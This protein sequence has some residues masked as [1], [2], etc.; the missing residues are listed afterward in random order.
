[1]QVKFVI[2]GDSVEVVI[3]P[4]AP[5]SVA[6]Q[7]ALQL[8]NNTARP[9]DDWELRDDVGRLL[10]MDR[11]FAD[12]A[13]LGDNNYLYVTRRVGAGGAHKLERISP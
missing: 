12:H 13:W 4:A 10:S 6:V 5:L 11:S 2:N 3:D 9:L 7:Q 1:M 8:S